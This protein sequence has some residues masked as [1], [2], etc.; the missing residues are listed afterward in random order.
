VLCNGNNDSKMAAMTTFD[1][2]K[3]LVHFISC[4]VKATTNNKVQYHTQAHDICIAVTRW[5]PQS[6]VTTTYI[7]HEQF[8]CFTSASHDDNNMAKT[9]TYVVNEPLVRRHTSFILQK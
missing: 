8:F 2:S 6:A 4:G 1:V 5:Q 7:G 3:P 9:T